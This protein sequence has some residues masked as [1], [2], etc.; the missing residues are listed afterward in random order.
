M[1][2]SLYYHEYGPSHTLTELS[3]PPVVVLVHG[4]FGS[5]DNLTVIRRHLETQYRVVNIDLPDH[6]LSPHSERFSFENYARQIIL[7]LST[8]NISKASVI[9]HSLGAKVAMWLAYLAPSMVD[10]LICL[11]IAPVAY[12]RRHENVINALTSVPLGQ[13]TSR[14]DAH[15]HMANFI[16]DPS[17]IA[18]LL[19]SLF[20]ENGT[21]RWRFNLSLLVRD[22]ALLSDWSLSGQQVYNGVVLFIK[23]ERSDYILAQY[24]DAIKIQFPKARAKLVNAGHWLHAEKPQVVNSLITKHLLG[25]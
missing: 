11:D 13:I 25:N 24:E 19:K 17:T 3:T 10:K 5:S 12:T 7:T 22:Y 4:L 15:Q 18:F 14:K 20:E 23:G 2:K 21:W 1:L 16:E 8:L 9:G 6:G